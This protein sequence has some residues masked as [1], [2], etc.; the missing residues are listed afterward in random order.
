M[1][2]TQIQLPDPLYAEVKRVAQMQDWS[3]TEVLRRGAEHIVRAYPADKAPASEWRMPAP[4]NLG[5]FV[6]DPSDWR[7]L[8]NEGTAE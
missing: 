7:D 4:A 3:V 2:R 1:K 6:A 8:A 5:E